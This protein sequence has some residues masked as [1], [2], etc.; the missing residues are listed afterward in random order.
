MR[1]LAKDPLGQ[2]N[3]STKYSLLP[4]HP[5]VPQQA[6]GP[7]QHR[8]L[9]T[10]FWEDSLDLLSCRDHWGLLVWTGA[11]FSRSFL[12][13]RGSIS[14]ASSFYPTLPLEPPLWVDG[15]DHTWLGWCWPVIHT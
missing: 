13:L 8:A 5:F 7:T 12:W 2:P 9:D 1:G 4:T 3:P 14:V 6:P 15:T 10:L 11:S